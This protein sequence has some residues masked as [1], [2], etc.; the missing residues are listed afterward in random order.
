MTG[1]RHRYVRAPDGAFRYV[2]RTR[3]GSTAQSVNIM[4]RQNFQSGR[5]LVAI[6]SQAASTG[7]SLQVL[8]PLT[9]MQPYQ[10]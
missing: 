2:P 10:A 6:I 9:L 4:E 7:I 1:R 8:P 5:K 3:E